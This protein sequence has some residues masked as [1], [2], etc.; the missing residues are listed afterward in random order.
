MKKLLLATLLITNTAFA[1]FD[2]F[3]KVRVSWE[4]VPEIDRNNPIAYIVHVRID[5]GQP[6][7]QTVSQDNTIDLPLADLGVNNGTEQLCFAIQ[8]SRGG[9]QSE[10]SD[11]RCVG[12]SALSAPGRAV[13]ELIP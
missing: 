10:L 3:S 5:S 6:W 1:Q 4:H 9:N 8:S 12:S 2:G 7:E 13:I 11:F